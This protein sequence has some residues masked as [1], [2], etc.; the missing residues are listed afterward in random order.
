MFGFC[1]YVLAVGVEVVVDGVEEGVAGDLGATAGRVVDVV[2][3]E[4]DHV[5]AAG[6][7][8]EEVVLQSLISTH[9][10]H[11]LL[12]KLL[13]WLS[14][15]ADQ[16]VEPS[17]SELEMVT[18]LEAALPRTRCWRPMREV[19]GIWSALCHGGYYVH[20]LGAFSP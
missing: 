19:W 16:L 13:T 2:T 11:M 8:D 20:G 9:L 12:L 14:Q 6:E 7:V 17:N 18:R 5:V 4:G 3:L 15:V 1:T 10:N